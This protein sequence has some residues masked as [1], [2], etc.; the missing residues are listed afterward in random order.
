MPPGIHS[1]P[2]IAALYNF[3][4]ALDGRG[5][6]IG[7]VELGGG[8]IPTD[9]ETYFRS[10]DLPIPDVTSV[11]V[12]GAKSETDDVAASEVMMN[13]EIIGAI[14]PRARLRMY[15]A[16]NTGTGFAHAVD[17]AVSDGVDVLSI[18]WGSPESK[19]IDQE[20]RQ[21]EAALERA[22]K[23]NVTVIAAA[24]DNGVT[25]GLTDGRRHVDFPASSEWV[26]AVGGTTLKSENG[27][28]I[29]ETV[30]KSGDTATATGG[31]ISEKIDR[32]AWQSAVSMPN[33]DD[34]KPGRGIPDVVASAAPEL[35]VSLI[36][37]GRPAVLGGTTKSVPLWVGLIARI[38]QALGYS[39]GYLN[40]RLYT[41]IGPADV[42]HTITS[43]DNSVSGV[44]GYSAGPGWSPVAGWGRPDGVKLL[45]WLQEHLTSPPG[46]QFATAACRPESNRDQLAA[47]P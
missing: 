9:V 16:P 22:A 46:H 17:R 7:I 26:L 19:W 28:I 42:L 20:F 13:L 27:K 37:H 2:E 15:F 29:S 18:D 44:T 33:R 23:Q 31:G 14:V 3:P 35:G 34:G 6:T 1:A 8:I 38:D 30:W 32:P 10:L 24:G 5:V 36:V 25:D 41:G 12:D 45:R 47:K 4:P 39:V 21:M 43:G 40:P 11:Y